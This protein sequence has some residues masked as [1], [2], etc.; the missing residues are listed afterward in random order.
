MAKRKGAS[1]TA[2]YA[3][4]EIETPRKLG[5]KRVLLVA[6]GDLRES[7]NRVCWPA[8]AK[9]ER[10]LA[11]AVADCGYE[12]VRAH[13][14]RS[15]VKHGFLASQKEGMQV[16]AGID[17]DAKL[18]V[19]E[20][21]WQYSH[22]VLHGL[23]SHRGPILTVANWSGQWPG[24][25]GMLNLN[26][27]MTKAGVR[28]ST[29]WSEDFRDPRFRRKLAAWLEKG[30]VTHRLSHVRAF[31]EVRVP[32]A[33]RK[34][35]EALAVQ[36]L[37]EK[38]IL[39]VFDEGC[40]GMYNAIIP[41]SLLN[42]V[43]VYKERLSQSAL[44][45][46]TYQVTEKEAREVYDWIRKAGMRFV[47]GNDDATEL[48]ESQVLTQ[49]KMYVAAMRIADEFGCD[50]IGIQYQ[51]G[52]KDCLP[53][54]DLAEG[55]LNDSNRPPVRSADG[56]RILYRG[57]PLPHFNEVDECAGL[58]ALLI[59]RVHRAMG[60]PVET[61]L[62]DLRWGDRDRSC[63]VPDYVWVFEISGSAPPSHFIG[64]WRG[65]VGERQPP[66]YFR[67]GG[68]T[69][70]GVSKPGEIV[71]SRIY[72]DRNRL[73][74]DIGRAGVVE[75]PDEET[76]RRWQATTPQWPI[77]HAVTYGVSRDQMMAK[78]KSNHVQVVYADGPAEADRALYARASM[79]RALGIEV[80]LC[81]TRKRGRAW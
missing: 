76:E 78:H 58:D 62:H 34:L 23:I 4:P 8:Q 67:L 28:Y 20:A 46:A 71:W 3:I 29:L 41:D 81:G 17:P 68:S 30:R 69:L 12:I 77:L 37:R 44:Y 6:S 75:L 36:L 47:F 42:E 2:G 70:K 66:M 33:E 60:Q 65:A 9:M 16:F 35:G 63:T 39:G 74:M 59:H 5:S 18:I 79:A 13:P 55:M 61:T 51:Q 31:D 10:D 1:G 11:A 24:L 49:C 64:G 80:H 38:A 56:K 25:V 73:H 43:G 21:V 22:H 15:K 54:S 48:T 45:Y 27:S 7:A 57:Q 32:R 52:L 53:A 40:M 72:V 14:Y 26:G 50:A 19:A